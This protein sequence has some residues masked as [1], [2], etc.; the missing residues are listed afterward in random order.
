MKFNLLKSLTVFLL[1]TAMLLSV[2]CSNTDIDENIDNENNDPVQETKEPK[3]LELNLVTYRANQ[4]TYNLFIDEFRKEYPEITVNV[5]NYENWDEY[6]FDYLK[7]DLPLGNAADVIFFDTLDTYNVYKLAEN[8][9]FAD[10]NEL[11]KKYGG[12]LKWDDYNKIVMDA[13]IID[14]KQLIMPLKHSLPTLVTTQDFLANNEIAYKDGA[15]LR[16]F[17]DS[18][19]ALFEG[20]E[21]GKD[22]VFSNWTFAFFPWMYTLGCD[23]EFKD[24]AHVPVINDKFYDMLDMYLEVY[25][26]PYNPTLDH[27]KYS[28]GFTDMLGVGDTMFISSNNFANLYTQELNELE[29]VSYIVKAHYDKDI[30]IIQY[31]NYD[32][33]EDS[34]VY[35]SQSLAILS[36]SPNLEAAYKFVSFMMNYDNVLIEFDLWNAGVSGISVNKKYNEK[37]KEVYSDVTKSKEFEKREYHQ[38]PQEFLDSYFDILDNVSNCILPDGNVWVMVSSIMSG[39]ENGKS[40]E[41][42]VQQYEESINRYL[43]E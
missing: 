13:G 5:K 36:Q 32:G 26:A 35:V 40:I 24:Y 31:P 19:M 43:Q 2:S 21:L 28:S 41:E 23:F 17:N 7:T 29:Y 1:I 39:I 38:M 37:L 8:G 6:I 11:D 14:G 18:V 42:A 25:P 10:I 33:V 22:L 16:E 9:L 27:S 15:T 30:A 20:K 3:Q 12:L 4:E 34:N